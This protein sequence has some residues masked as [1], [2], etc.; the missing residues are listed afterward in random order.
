MEK[1]DGVLIPLI[2]EEQYEKNIC[3]CNCGDICALSSRSL[4]LFPSF[5]LFS[6]SHFHLP[7]ICFYQKV[8]KNNGCFFCLFVFQLLFALIM[9]MERRA[10]SRPRQTL[11]HQLFPPNQVLCL[12]IERHTNISGVWT[13][14]TVCPPC[15]LLSLNTCRYFRNSGP[16]EIFYLGAF[17]KNSNMESYF[18]L[19]LFTSQSEPLY[20]TD[21][22]FILLPTL[23]AIYH[24]RWDFQAI[25]VTLKFFSLEVRLHYDSTHPHLLMVCLF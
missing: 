5:C 18:Y 11:S 24:Q 13:T 23:K 1:T 15:F 2:I 19:S 17:P 8:Y 7:N 6:C 21:T 3:T 22:V 25:V 20:Q 9:K 14:C 4:C 10:F 16:T 12:L